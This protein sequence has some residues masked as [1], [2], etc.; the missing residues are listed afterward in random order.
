MSKEFTTIRI[1]RDTKGRLENYGK[2]SMS[3]DDVLRDILDQ[4]EQEQDH[5]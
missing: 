5:D 3:Y 4:L 2:M 1:S